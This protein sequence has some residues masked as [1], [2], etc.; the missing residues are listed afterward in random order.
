MNECNQSRFYPNFRK[1]T[2]Q[3]SRAD[4]PH[5]LHSFA[6]RIKGKRLDDLITLGSG[7]PD[8]P[9]PIVFHENP[10]NFDNDEG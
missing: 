3:V 8:H 6:F 2:I 10:K 9:S 5:G 4:N 7:S 1:E